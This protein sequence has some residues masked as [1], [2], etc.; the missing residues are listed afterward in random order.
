MSQSQLSQRWNGQRIA[1]F[2]FI[3]I[4]LLIAGI[5]LGLGIAGETSFLPGLSPQLKVTATPVSDSSTHPVLTGGLSFGQQDAQT[6]STNLIEVAKLARPAVVNISTT[7]TAKTPESLRSPF[8]DDPFF[9]RFF[10]DEFERRF[11]PPPSPRQ[12]GG[13]SGVIV[14]D[15]GYIITNNH[16]IE[17]SEA[18]QVLLSDKRTFT[19]EVIGTDPKTDLALLK[20]DAND[21]PVLSWGDSRQLQVGE[22]VMAVGNPF[23]LSQTVTMGIVSAVGRANVGIVD[24]E[25]FIQTD[26]AI[27]PGNSGG[28][29]VN[30]QGE[31]IGI[32]TAIFSRSGGYMGIGFAI[33][34]NMAKSIQASLIEHGNVVRGWLGVSIQD[35]TPD[36]Q[37]Q[38]DT[39]DT[40]GA[41]VSEVMEDSPA[42]KAGIQR[43]D[44]IRIYDSQTVADT[45]HLR[46][47]VAESVPNSPVKLQVLRDG[48]PREIDVTL[49]EM[50]KDLRAFASTGELRGNHALAGISVESMPIGERGVKVT[51]VEPENAATRAGIREGDIILEINREAVDN[52]DD[53][54]RL[55]GELGSKDRILLL[56]QRG[57]ST[58]FLSVTP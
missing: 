23:G 2:T 39:P 45:R 13:G 33:P 21:L 15:D 18:I 40:Q 58:I 35:L 4:A 3:G 11:E 6:Q 1:I 29:L 24:Y 57:R 52:A 9:R 32:N 44:I 48:T 37:A 34:S 36:L 16:V 47:L 28:A 38:F 12:E 8:F 26:A 14:S 49:S 20:I 17:N 42:K 27:N 22:I 46:S 5:C 51:K 50:P 43:G 41:L 56:I 54:Q 19:A 30:L 10:G 25:D 7:G 31:L 55:T 53:F